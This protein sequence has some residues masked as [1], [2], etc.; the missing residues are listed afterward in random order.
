MHSRQYI[1]ENQR[2]QRTNK[3]EK[4]NMPHLQSARTLVIHEILHSSISIQAQRYC[5]LMNVEFDQLPQGWGLAVEGSK[6]GL[7]MMYHV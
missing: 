2:I 7:D 6:K 5:Q 3:K 4:F 1:Y